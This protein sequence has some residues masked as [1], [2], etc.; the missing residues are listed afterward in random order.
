M[1]TVSIIIE[2]IC[3]QAPAIPANLRDQQA[4]LYG[5]KDPFTGPEVCS[6]YGAESNNVDIGP[7][8]FVPAKFALE[9]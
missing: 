4:P 7:D 8:I 6:Y 3:D 9:P 5:K 1:G 2:I